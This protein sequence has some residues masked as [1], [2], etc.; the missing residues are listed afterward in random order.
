MVKISVLS[1]LTESLTTMEGRAL[2][3]QRSKQTSMP[4]FPHPTTKTLFP[5]NISP[6]LYLL[7]CTTGPPN[8]FIPSNSGITSTAFSPVATISHR[9]KYSFVSS[10][11]K[12]VVL[13]L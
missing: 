1:K 13:T 10:F 6:L 2:K 5:L 12:P 11:F 9:H 3:L 4:E 7:V 8:S